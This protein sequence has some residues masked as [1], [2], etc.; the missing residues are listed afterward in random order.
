MAELSIFDCRCSWFCCIPPKQQ[1]S[2]VDLPPIIHEPSVINL[3]A[4]LSQTKSTPH[5]IINQ[6]TFFGPTLKS[7]THTR[8]V[9]FKII[10]VNKRIFLGPI[11]LFKVS[12]LRLQLPIFKYLSYFCQTF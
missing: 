11:L 1:M 10:A 9:A 4:Y 12:S 6:R 8:T 2:R 5:A 3:K 7:H